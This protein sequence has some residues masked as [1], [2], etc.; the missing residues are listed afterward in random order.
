M[1]GRSTRTRARKTARA[2][3][4]RTRTVTPRQAHLPRSDE[5]AHGYIVEQLKEAP[6]DQKGA[7]TVLASIKADLDAA[8]TKFPSKAKK[9]GFPS[10]KP[11]RL[12]ISL[13][14]DTPKHKGSSRV[15]GK[16]VIVFVSFNPVPPGHEVA[17]EHI[18]D[19]EATC[20]SNSNVAQGLGNHWCCYSDA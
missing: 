13:M 6:K 7:K 12:E 5:H 11:P 2:A 4:P 18:H 3:T 16:Q 9:H 20:N 10:E 8:N 1:P 15:P 14:E 19:L 17:H